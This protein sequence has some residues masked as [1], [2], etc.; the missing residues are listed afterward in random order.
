VLGLLPPSARREGVRQGLLVLGCVALGALPAPV[1]VTTASAFEVESFV[2]VHLLAAAFLLQ[3]V[4]D[5]V[6]RKN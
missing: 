6:R 3:A 1:L 4:V 2:V 5:R